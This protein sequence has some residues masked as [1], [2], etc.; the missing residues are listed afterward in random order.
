MGDNLQVAKVVGI[1]VDRTKIVLFVLMGALSA[2]AGLLLTIENTTFWATQGSGFLLIVMAAVFI[3]GTSIFGGQGV[4]VGTFFGSFIVGSI[5]AGI[6]A[7]GIQGFYTRLVVGLVLLIA[8]SFHLFM[9]KAD[10]RATIV[11]FFKF[12]K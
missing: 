12:N 6:V 11:N 1:N 3:G 8:I 9:E 5:E 10:K 4:I 7:T 2:F